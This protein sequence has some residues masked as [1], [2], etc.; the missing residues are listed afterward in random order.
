MTVTPSYTLA[1]GYSLRRATLFDLR[2]IHRLEQ[3]IF[4]RDAYPYLDLGML[5]I[6]PGVINL[7]ITAPDRSLAGFLSAT[8]GL[9][10]ERAW[11]ITVGVSPAH[12]R[13]GLGAYLMV[14]T[15]RRIHRPYVRLTVREGNLTAIRL[16]EKLGYTIIDRKISYYRDGETGLIM[17][18]RVPPSF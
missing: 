16:Y 2:Q 15:E 12:Q 5:F 3:V 11:I 1:Q 10:P 13:R 17:Q 14:M 8:R 7:K 9:S 6:W 4:P 18:K